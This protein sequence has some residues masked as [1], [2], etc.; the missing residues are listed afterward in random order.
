VDEKIKQLN[1]QGEEIQN[2]FIKDNLF[3][4]LR[5]EEIFNE[6]ETLERYFEQTI[7]LIDQ[8]GY[9][10]VSS[11]DIDVELI[12]GQ[13][14][15]EEIQGVFSG[16]VIE[17]R[18]N[19]S[20]FFN[21][22][23][24][25]IAYPIFNKDQEV[26]FALYLHSEVSG[27]L[28][29]KEGIFLIVALSFIFGILGIV[30]IIYIFTHKMTV[31][32]AYLN[33]G[34]KAL[35]KGAYDYPL[36]NTRKDEIGQLTSSMK[37]MSKDLQV[38]ENQRRAFI[39]DISHDFRS[40]LTNIIG[41]SKGLLDHKLESVERERY[42]NIILEESYRLLHLSDDILELSKLQNP[43][44]DL[45]KD[46]F[47]FEGLVLEVVDTYEKRIEDKN[48]E[49]E[50]T[51]NLKGKKAYGDEKLIRRVLQNLL[52]NSIKFNVQG[53][54]FKILTQEKEKNLS[55]EIYNDTDEVLKLPLDDLFERFIKG[56]PS[57]NKSRKSFGLGL[58]IV[59]EILELHGSQ[60][61]AQKKD[62]GLLIS[63][64]LKS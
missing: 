57:R 47:D 7:W 11:A 5:T 16:Q 22:P 51:F 2:A 21:E 3:N 28:E 25:T 20:N 19:N 63:F 29:A 37:K 4:S 6:I 13:L 14:D 36:V 54:R 10:Y 48:L 58:S 31:D 41:F 46:F 15:L 8:R 32:L 24:I 18:R 55:I 56:D 53:G 49:V 23:V 38:Y 39:S 26:V 52:D 62:D 60:L 59:K 1:H 33:D 35:S 9:I 44:K 43:K 50:I 42:L 64:Y 27:V 17:K 45:E 34:V 30:M 12:E 40:P 61:E